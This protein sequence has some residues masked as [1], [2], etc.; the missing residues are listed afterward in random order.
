ML[1]QPKHALLLVG[2]GV[3]AAGDFL[4]EGNL[5][6]LLADPFR[7]SDTLA[8]AIVG[9][10]GAIVA[11][12]IAA[13]SNIVERVPRRGPLGLSALTKLAGFSA[14]AIMTLVAWFA[15][16][17]TDPWYLAI[18]VVVLWLVHAPSEGLGASAYALAI[19]R[20]HRIPPAVRDKL[21]VLDY[22]GVNLSGVVASVVVTLWRLAWGPTHIG[23][24]N[25]AV[26]ATAAG[27][28]VVAGLLAWYAHLRLSDG[29][30]PLIE[31]SREVDDALNDLLP[32]CPAA[33]RK[34]EDDEAGERG[35]CRTF[36]LAWFLLTGARFLMTS[37]AALLPKYL[38]RRLGDPTYFALYLAI[39]PALITVLS[40]ATPLAPC[41]LERGRHLHWIIAGLTLQVVS[42]AFPMLGGAGESWPI[43]SMIVLAT[44]G[45][46][47]SWTRVEAWLV[48]F[49]ESRELPHWRS[50]MAVPGAVLGLVATVSSGMLFDAYCPVTATPE[51][52]NPWLWAWVGG[53]SA[54]A[55]ILL[56]LIG[57]GWQKLS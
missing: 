36:A 5:L 23:M 57:L 40:L 26:F 39:N 56:A 14:L 54:T 4:S 30:E 11:L 35:R 45:E 16:T 2:H 41:F 52:C 19:R 55:P 38:V 47:L 31:P 48:S 42:L 3:D 17:S 28:F 20:L 1:C 12:T 33:C 34:D 27:L 18:V 7:V 53:V 49:G 44:I 37:M 50:A 43:V 22:G 10:Y 51:Q 9:V 6:F 46:G 29:D 13:T 25:V 15:T 21:Y 32:S 8:A 24:A